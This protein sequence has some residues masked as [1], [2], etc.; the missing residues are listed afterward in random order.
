MQWTFLDSGPGTGQYNMDTDLAL[1]ESVP[2]SGAVFRIYS[3]NPWCVSLGKNQK[4]QEIDQDECQRL[5]FD[6]V[7]RPT[8]GRAVLHAN[9]LTYSVL[10]PIHSAAQARGWY[11]AIHQFILNALE[12]S[13]IYGLEFVRNTA[14]LRSHYKNAVS[15]SC[16]T[17]SARHEIQFNGK[18]V[19][20]SAQRIL[21]N[22]ILLQ[23]GSILL[24]NGHE[25]LADISVLPDTDSKKQVKEMLLNSSATL[26]QVAGK[27]I[28]YQECS[29]YFQEF[30]HQGNSPVLECEN[31]DI[32]L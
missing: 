28:S 30:I 10:V 29:G 4:I 15:V 26:T 3:W 12:S 16:F 9:E 8:G 18:K 24:D 7:R 22:G 17:A 1:A 31:R 20:G 2:Q 11:H 19:I 32:L 21:Q 25:L 6:I 5:G 13:G 27:T 14:D 23:H